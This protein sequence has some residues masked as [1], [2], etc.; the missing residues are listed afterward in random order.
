MNEEKPAGD[1]S[2]FKTWLY[3]FLF[4]AGLS[5]VV[6]AAHLST[7]PIFNTAFEVSVFYIPTVILFIIVLYLKVRQPQPRSNR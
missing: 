3:A 5:L 1:G 2:E 7:G 6:L 4:M